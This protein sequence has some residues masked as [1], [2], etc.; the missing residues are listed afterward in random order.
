LSYSKIKNPG[1]NYTEINTYSETGIERR[2]RIRVDEVPCL[3]VDD[4]IKLTGWLFTI[5]D[6][7][8]VEQ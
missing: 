7:T 2:M 4:E 5:E 1:S 6:I 8:K 3:V